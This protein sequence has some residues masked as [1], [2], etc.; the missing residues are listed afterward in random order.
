M[1][2]LICYINGIFASLDEASLPVQDL[3]ILRGYGVFDFLRTYNGKPFKLQE[4][5]RRLE[6]SAK[7]I[8]LDL[9]H[10]NEPLLGVYSGEY[11][12]SVNFIW[13]LRWTD[14]FIIGKF[15]F[16]PTFIIRY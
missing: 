6:N 15:D 2:E 16:L 7:L 5:L 8:L 9:P 10:S 4:H 11:V 13:F 12:A 14:V 3:A 1:S